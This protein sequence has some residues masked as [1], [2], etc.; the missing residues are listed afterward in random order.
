[1]SSQTEAAP[2]GLPLIGSFVKN[3][4]ARGQHNGSAGKGVCCQAGKPE[5][6]PNSYTVE[7]RT[8]PHMLSRC[9][10]E[11]QNTNFKNWGCA[12]RW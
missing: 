7:E 9:I 1:M 2:I 6:N 4:T 3:K 11:R 12:G 5:F 10:N 8:N